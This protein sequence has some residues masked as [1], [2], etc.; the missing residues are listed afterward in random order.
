M[1][2]YKERVGMCTGSVCVLGCVYMERVK[3]VCVQGE[4]VYVHRERVCAW[5]CVHGE[6][7][8]CVCVQGEG[9]YVHRERV[10]V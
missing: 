8:V 5:V 10:C 1:Y 2:V 9:V 3:C 6:G 4:G 7:V